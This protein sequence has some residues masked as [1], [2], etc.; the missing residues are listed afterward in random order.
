MKPG[1]FILLFLLIISC[2]TAPDFERTNIKDPKGENFKPNRP[3][4]GNYVLD[5]NGNI[6]L[7]WRDNSQFEDGFRV[8]KSISG[9]DFELQAELLKNATSFV[10][11]TREFGVPTIYQVVSYA[12]T[13]ES[14]PLGFQIDLGIIRN[15]QTVNNVN[16]KEIKVFWEDQTKISS[17]KAIEYSLNNVS[18]IPLDTLSQSNNSFTFD[19]SELESFRIYFRVINF[20]RDSG[21]Q[22]RNINSLRSPE[23]KIYQPTNLNITPIFEDEVL[24]TWEDN[25]SFE[26]GYEIKHSVDGKTVTFNVPENEEEIQ[27][28]ITPSFNNHNFQ[29]VG[30]SQNGSSKV[31]ST[32]RSIRVE[33]PWNVTLTSQSKSNIKIDWDFYTDGSITRKIFLERKINDESEFSILAELEPTVTSY[34]DNSL[35]T[36]SSYSYRLRTL[37]SQTTNELSITYKETPI[38]DQIFNTPIRGRLALTNDYLHTFY[39]TEDRIGNFRYILNRRN[40]STGIVNTRQLNYS[41]ELISVSPNGEYVAVLKSGWDSGSWDVLVYGNS[42][43]IPLIHTFSDIS[44]HLLH[45][46]IFSHDSKKILALDHE[47]GETLIYTLDLENTETVLLNRLNT[48]CLESILRHPDSNKYILDCSRNFRILD[49]EDFSLSTIYDS[50]TSNGSDNEF[51]HGNYFHFTAREAPIIRLDLTNLSYTIVESRNNNFYG[52]VPEKNHYILGYDSGLKFLDYNTR[53]TF[54]IDENYFDSGSIYS[55]SYN[56]LTER[57]I[58]ASREDRIE[59]FRYSGKWTLKR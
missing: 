51:V 55:V 49:A 56:P 40:E 29:V 33:A 24:I 43:S 22:V 17:Q 11:S 4:I 59:Y 50:P 46:I 38:I 53:E 16:A 14:S 52:F 41:P 32:T 37:S 39:I 45:R 25:S 23:L 12:D 57:L 1:I 44:D 7:S 21:N 58:L 27:T 48:Y 31:L 9:Q 2:S 10:D 36:S 18:W 3:N 28:I 8:Y 6:T 54:F 42:N 13:I 47:S 5:N 30:I 20:I 26:T 34:I 35:S 19:Y 15:I